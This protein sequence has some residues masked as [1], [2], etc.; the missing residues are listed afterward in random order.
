METLII[1]GVILGLA[2]GAIISMYYYKYK[3]TQQLKEQSAVLLK[4]IKQVFKLVTVEGEFSEIFTHR[5]GKNIFF[6][7]LQLEKKVILIVKAKVMVGFDLSQ[8]NIQVNSASKKIKLSKF[9]HPQ[10]ISIDTDL[11]YYD[12]QKGMINKLSEK[13]LT[14][15]SKK[16]KDFIRE[17]VD[18]SDLYIIADKQ[19]SETIDFIGQLASSVGWEMITE[20]TQDKLEES[21][22]R[23]I[24]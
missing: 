17:K 16:A 3:N 20:K 8:I 15:I 18:D 5:N 6:N 10:I 24:Q 9:P 1:L 21:I 22:K 14:E 19:V 11:E 12:I 7:L 13:D 23:Q 2:A 4:Q